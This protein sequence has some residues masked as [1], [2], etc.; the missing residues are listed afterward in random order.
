MA[1]SCILL[2]SS[3]HYFS[4]TSPTLI[5]LPSVPE[6]N[7][8]NQL[9]T[10][11]FSIIKKPW[12]SQRGWVLL[13]CWATC[14]LCGPMRQSGAREQEERTP[15]QAG[16]EKLI[17]NI[18]SIVLPYTHTLYTFNRSYFTIQLTVQYRMVMLVPTLRSWAQTSVQFHNKI[19][20]AAGSKDLRR[21]YRH[22]RVGGPLMSANLF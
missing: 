14:L 5:D 8:K 15:E 21:K 6:K 10:S 13:R 7:Q 16:R 4:K 17:N 3:G 2:L 19:S 18:Q 1:S 12:G 9:S 22:H 11:R 20:C